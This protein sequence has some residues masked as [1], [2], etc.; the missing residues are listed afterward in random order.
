RHLASRPD[1]QRRLRQDPA[2]IPNAVEEL[3]R[4]HGLTCTS[5][6]VV[7]ECER[8]GARLMPDDMVMVPPILAGM[9]DR[10]YDKPMEID[11]DRDFAVHYTL[12]HGPHKCLG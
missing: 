3:L 5:H 10:L 4:R 12:G 11:F 2:V 6:L 1:Q 8:K 9:D 7:R